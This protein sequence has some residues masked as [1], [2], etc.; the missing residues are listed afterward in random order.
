MGAGPDQ[1]RKDGTSRD[2]TY[3]LPRPPANLR[4]ARFSVDSRAGR[5]ALPLVI[6]AVLSAAPT[7]S[8]NEV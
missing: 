2:P 4:H 1:S 8:G 5:Q 7:V 3:R 6:C